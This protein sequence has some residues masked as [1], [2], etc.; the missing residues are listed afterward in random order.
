VSGDRAP[1]GEP[2]PAQGAC[3]LARDLYGPLF[4]EG[5]DRALADALVT[6]TGYTG[7][8][9]ARSP[10]VAVEAHGCTFGT[11]TIAVMLG[12]HLEIR[13]TDDQSYMPELAGTHSPATLALVP[14]GDPV[15]LYPEKPGRFALTDLLHS[16]MQADVFVLRFST[17]AVT[18]LDGRYEIS[19]IPVGEVMVNALLPATLQVAERR[20]R[21]LPNQSVDLDLQIPFERKPRAEE[22]S[23]P[24]RRK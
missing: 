14:R 8:V 11:R 17:F 16:Y 24:R 20:V 23:A 19:G 6:V 13:S 15:K 3:R 7:H 2:V 22:L 12:Q 1:Q 4:R 18:R 5:M 21:V 10:A 9:P